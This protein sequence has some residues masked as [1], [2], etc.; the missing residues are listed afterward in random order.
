[1]G[2]SNAALDGCRE[3]IRIPTSDAPESLNLASAVQLACYEL[4]VAALGGDTSVTENTDLPSRSELDF[5]V[6]TLERALHIR[7][8][9]EGDRHASTVTRLR[10]LLARSRPNRGDLEYLHGLVKLMRPPYSK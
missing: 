5:S 8:F 7:S 2:L 9:I 1:M 3:E 6:A 4:R 10:R